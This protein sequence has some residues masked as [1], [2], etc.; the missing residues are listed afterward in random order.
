MGLLLLT[1][2]ANVSA[3]A[4]TY[5]VSTTS[6]SG[7]GSLRQ[8]ILDANASPAT[9]FIQF[10]IPGTGP[11]TIN[12]LS[13]LP[14]LAGAV[15]IDA[16]TQ[17]G[18]IG[19][20]LIELNGS[21]A[22]LESI[23]IRV[24]SSSCIIR[25]LAINRFATDGIRLESTLNTVQ[26]T[27]IG[28]DVTGTIARPNGQYGIFVLGGWSN[29]I[30]G[31]TI[32]ARNVI[33]GGNDTGIY[34]LNCF[35]NIVQ[36]NYIGIS[37]PGTTDLGNTN[38]G[39]TLFNSADNLIGGTTAGAR[40][41]IAGNNG[42]GINLNAAGTAGNTIQGNYFGLNAAGTAS[43]SNS[44]DGITLN[45]AGQNLIGGTTAGAGNIISGNGKAGI[46][47]NG[48]NCRGNLVQGNWI[49]L[50]AAGT[51]ARGNVFA[52]VT[53]AGAISNVLGGNIAAAR[54]VIAGNLQEG[55]FLSSTSRSNRIHG[56]Y[57]GTQP[58]GTSAL[59]NQAS[60]VALNN[61]P[62]NF[63]GGSNSG[64]GNL[65]SGNNYLGI[66]LINTNSTRNFVR[67]NLIGVTAN[68]NAALGN[69]QAG[70]GLSD[71]GNNQIGGASASE[72]NIISGNGFPANSGGLFIAGSLATGNRVLGNHIGTD[73]AG[74]A[75][76][77]NR[78]EGVYITSANSNRIGGRLTGEGNLIA[79]NTTRGLRLTNSLYTDILGNK[80]GVR[81]DGT[82]S[83]ANGQ[84]N[85]ELEER[86]SFTRIGA[87]NGGG[88]RIGYSGGGFAGIRVRDLSTNNAI[89]G[90]AIFGSSNL[91]ID[92]STFG[93]T[94][95]DDCDAD[96]GG[97]QLQNFPVLTQAYGGS[98]TGIRGTFNSK[99]NQ[100][101]RLQFFAS[102]TCD[103][104]GNGE[105]E[106]YLGDTIV[107]TGPSCSTNFAVSLPVA[108]GIGQVITATATDSAN[109]T[110]EFSACLTTLP[111]PTLA[112]NSG[113]A[114]NPVTLQWP[115][116]ATGFLLRETSSL[117][118]PA[119][120]TL[121]TN[122]PVNLSGQLT[123]TITPQGDQRFYRL[124]LE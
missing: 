106:V 52:G 116:S 29:T 23:G 1:L 64:E 72:R 96:G 31:T 7:A 102:A 40:N 101:Y 59:P 44:A 53:M 66:W 30:G 61:A 97:N 94:A 3:F 60:G 46:F 21:N 28:T 68:G 33:G 85:I 32:T 14:A 99:P 4:A 10:V 54:N 47:L 110:S 73:S 109:N 49:G 88:N 98:T 111:T 50:D 100:T 118:P 13:Q 41:I 115:A 122:A 55:I 39:I 65:I 120:W 70:V 71:A 6:D 11:F 58:N 121:T 104:S 78:F 107:Q 27:Y 86:T 26:G 108:V 15:T 16:T 124:S 77:A 119:I 20:P 91:G 51:T 83:L 67:G 75:A 63:I 81:I 80:F 103:A 76:I 56:N 5:T 79:G 105:G 17:P 8:A 113:G 25:G 45:D 42:S 24:T 37:A 114:G 48:P 92:N 123:V 35:G 22:G 62:D 38:N 19:Q 57:I 43:V 90:N 82:N 112:I 9:D 87:T 18:Y 93:V 84:F 12:L 2:T 74:N 69:V 117:S 36:G 89:L 34:L 95:N